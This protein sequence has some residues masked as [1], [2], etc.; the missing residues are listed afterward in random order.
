[1]QALILAGGFG[2][3]LRPLTLNLPKPVVPLVNRPILAYQIELLKRAGITDIILSLNYQPD[4]IVEVIGNGE[5]YGVNIRYVVEP[6]P[7][8]TAGAVKFAEEFITQTTVILNGDNLINLD[9]AVVA[10]YHQQLNA[11]ATIV[12]QRIENPIGY[13][14]VEIDE[15]NNV[16]NF[17]EKPSA[18]T[19]TKIPT[20]TVNAGTYILEPK[21]LDLIPSG[22]NYSFEYGVFPALLKRKEKFAAF[23]DYGYWLD[24]GTPAR[25]LHAHQEII[26]QKVS[27]FSGED[28]RGESI[29]SAAQICPNSIIGKSCVIKNGAKIEN[30]VLGEN[31]VIDENCSIKDSVIL[32]NTTFG[33]NVTIEGAIIANDCKIGDSS[34]ISRETILGEASHLT[35]YSKV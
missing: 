32:Q 17:L 7:L 25:Y 33:K 30:S 29:V 35:D 10:E 11:A 23:L 8:G 2:T 6:E 18:E 9:I 34:I 24:V 28:F 13:G 22:E 1:M 19:L 21:V 4:K 3:R 12:L 14:L 5:K 26:N 31:V 20:R 27:G 15:L 16:L